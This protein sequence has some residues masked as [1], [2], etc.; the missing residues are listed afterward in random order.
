[1][2]ISPNLYNFLS[3][4][5]RED[6]PFY[7]VLAIMVLWAYSKG[8]TMINLE[9]KENIFT[10]HPPKNK[11]IG[12][13]SIPHSGEILPPEF[14]EFV[15]PEW[16]ILMRDVDFRVHELI[17]IEALQNAGI[18][19]IN[20][21]IIRTAVDLNRPKETALLN[22]K[23][24][25]FGEQVVLKEPTAEQATELTEIYYSPYYEMIKALINDLRPLTKMPSFIDLHS[26]PSH[27]TE[28]HLKITP[29]Q[30]KDRPD[31]CISDIEGL[32]CEKTFIDQICNK[33]NEDYPQV[34]Q[35]NPYYGGHVTRHVHAEFK[36]TNNIQIEI[37]RNIYMD[38]QTKTL[39]E[40]KVLKLKPILTN[41]LIEVFETY[42]EKYKV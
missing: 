23:N 17:D 36:N 34:N 19:V 32:S 16:D 6:S 21:H 20:A 9:N 33:L 42:F 4:F 29:N 25:S 13:L 24:N 22:W 12:I 40:N 37:K 15:S 18:A 39:E 30:S 1:M 8:K 14:K 31:F 41:A 7:K 38:E 11:Y 2:L 26:M 3:D 28:Y 10:Y 27:P 35:N 5:N